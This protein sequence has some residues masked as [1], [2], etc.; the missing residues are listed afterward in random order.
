[1]KLKDLLPL[2]LRLGFLNET[3]SSSLF[4]YFIGSP[5]YKVK[6]F[7]KWGIRGHNSGCIK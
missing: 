6:N 7:I 3:F 1:M 2:E 4:H 5:V